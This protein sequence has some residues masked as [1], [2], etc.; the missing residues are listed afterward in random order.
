MI[1]V[2]EDVSDPDGDEP[3]VGESLVEWVWREMAVEDLG[4]A[5]LDQEAQE[6]GDVIDAFVGQFESGVHGVSPTSGLGKP[7]L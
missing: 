1:G 2:G 4:E 7:S 3:A 5:E 6:Q